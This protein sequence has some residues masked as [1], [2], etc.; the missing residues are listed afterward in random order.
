MQ[1]TVTKEE[2]RGL[3]VRQSCIRFL[4]D[5]KKVKS[6][7]VQAHDLKIEEGKVYEVRTDPNSSAICVTR[8][9]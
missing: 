7:K 1:E 9:K 2:L 3:R 5:M 8:V 4:A 6:I